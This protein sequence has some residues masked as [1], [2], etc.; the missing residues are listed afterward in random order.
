MADILPFEKPVKAKPKKRG[1]CTH[2]H[3]KWQV[4]K[5]TQFDVKSGKLV[6]RYQCGRC[7]KT[8]VKAI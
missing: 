8:K 3:H 2:G 1:L 6:T 5:S 4:V 7:G